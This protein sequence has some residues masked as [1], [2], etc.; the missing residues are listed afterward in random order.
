MKKTQNLVTQTLTVLCA[1]MVIF[2]EFVLKSMAVSDFLVALFCAVL[3]EA[4]CVSASNPDPTH[5]AL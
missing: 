1:F 2:L 3:I 5:L 4:F